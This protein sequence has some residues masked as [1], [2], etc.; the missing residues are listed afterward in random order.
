MDKLTVN[1]RIYKNIKTGM[2]VIDRDEYSAILVAISQLASDTVRK[3]LGPYAHTTII[4]D[5]TFT[6]PTKDGWSVLNR[7]RF[8]DPIYNTL[9][10]LIKDISFRIVNKVGDGTTTAI[11]AANYFLNELNNHI[12]KCDKN[13]EKPIRQADLIKMIDTARDNVIERLKSTYCH[14]IDPMGDM[15]DIRKIAYISS[16]GD[17]ELA[18]AI[19]NIYKETHNPNILVQLGTTKDLE[20]EIQH[21]YRLDCKFLNYKGYINTE[22]GCFKN[23]SNEPML[24]AIFDHNVTYTQHM[25]FVS[26]IINYANATGKYVV[27]MAPYFDDVIASL[28]QSKIEECFSAHQIPSILLIQTAMSSTA[29]KEFV[30]DF[31]LIT[32]ARMID[33]AK[34]K[35]YNIMSRNE[36]VPPEERVNDDILE[37]QEFKLLDNS[38]SIITSSFGMIRDASIASNHITIHEYEKTPMYFNTLLEVETTFNEAKKKSN[39]DT[40]VLNREYLDIYQRYTRLIGTM[41]I[42]R[43]GGVSELEKHCKKDAVD[44]AV[45]ACQSAFDE[46]FVAGLN[47][48]TI[49]AIWDCMNIVGEESNPAYQFMYK[50][51]VNTSLDVLRNKYPAKAKY[52]MNEAF[53]DEEIIDKCVSDYMDYGNV[54]AFNI[55]T[56]SFDFNEYGGGEYTVINSIS[57]D[58]EIIYAMCSI[59]TL[60]LSSNQFLSI[61][62][63]YDKT[64]AMNDALESKVNNEKAIW[65]G[66]LSAIDAYAKENPNGHIGKLTEHFKS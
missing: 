9:F 46:G 44:D 18:D 8:S 26:G 25:N 65:T 14:R 55:V 31:A 24:V 40:S 13:N 64:E 17:D 62:R 15:E 54:R 37:V 39:K 6:Y 38:S 21:G 11:V 19:Y 59:L 3:T 34:V 5:G 49:G 51:F 12:E 22:D 20:Y 58:I 33:G 57:T 7:L 4:D 41:G 48:A 43:V 27:I 35:A 50:A 32:G 60:I 47:V 53:T 1:E 36:K 16:N 29:Q 61:N 42:I 2:N 66:I 30:G 28:L 63:T 45:L 23:P 52:W 56:E 10:K